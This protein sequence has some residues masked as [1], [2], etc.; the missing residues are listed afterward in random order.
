MFSGYREI[1]AVS[2][3]PDLDEALLATADRTDLM[4]ERRTEASGLVL[5]TERANHRGPIVSL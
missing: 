1:G 2:G 3:T 4:T 5:S